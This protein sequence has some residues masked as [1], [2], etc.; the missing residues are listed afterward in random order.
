[1]NEGFNIIKPHHF[2]DFLYDLGIG[3][4]HE[5][6][7]NIFGNRNGELCQEFIDGKMKRIKFTPLADDICKPCKKLSGGE[8]CTDCFDDET[9]FFYG[10]QHK[11]D[12]NYQ[13]D[14]K[15]NKALP[16]IFCFD[17][18]WAMCDVLCE[19]D[20]VLTKEII[21]LYKWQRPERAEKTF[22]GIKKGKTIYSDH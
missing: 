7:A 19:L 14:M 8:V 16:K 12:F 21:D 6:E 15:L 9:A 1:M 13:L 5:D 10:F 18:I 20:K 4:R 17:K 3:Y 11:V 2:L 22:E